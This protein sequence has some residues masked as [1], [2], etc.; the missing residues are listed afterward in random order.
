[1]R[2]LTWEKNQVKHKIAHSV[3]ARSGWWLVVKKR[4]AIIAVS[5]THVVINS[6]LHLVGSVDPA[7]S[8]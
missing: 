6:L 5:K 7:P 4:Y 8:W 2:I 1:M 3:E